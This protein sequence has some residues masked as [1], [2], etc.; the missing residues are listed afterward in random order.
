MHSVL[1]FPVQRQPW[2]VMGN[3]VAHTL[4][5]DGGEINCLVH[6]F[7]KYTCLAAFPITTYDTFDSMRS[8][9]FL[10][11]RKTKNHLSRLHRFC[12]VARWAKQEILKCQ[13]SRLQVILGYFLQCEQKTLRPP[14]MDDGRSTNCVGCMFWYLLQ[15]DQNGW[16]ILSSMAILLFGFKEGFQCVMTLSGDK[17]RSGTRE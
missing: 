12:N 11:K 17:Q 7:L 2:E 3:S 14:N 9:P 8:L 16:E 10:E 6:Q 5:L 15:Q 13:S 4:R 1:W